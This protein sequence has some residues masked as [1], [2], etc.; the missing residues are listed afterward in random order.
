MGHE[1][2]LKLHGNLNFSAFFSQRL[3]ALDRKRAQHKPR[4]CGILYWLMKQHR[5]LR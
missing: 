2:P 4:G 5:P 1:T 3:L